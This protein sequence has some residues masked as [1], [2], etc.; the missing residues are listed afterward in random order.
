MN[1]PQTADHCILQARVRYSGLPGL[2]TIP[3][4]RVC[5]T[6]ALLNTFDTGQTSLSHPHPGRVDPTIIGSHVDKHPVDTF[7]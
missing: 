6:D 7:D 2:Q 4:S 5:Q 3:R 1:E